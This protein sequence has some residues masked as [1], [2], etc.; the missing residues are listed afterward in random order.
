MNKIVFNMLWPVQGRGEIYGVC[1]DSNSLILIPI[2]L[3]KKRAY[4]GNIL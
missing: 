1:H 2:L 4:H 3:M